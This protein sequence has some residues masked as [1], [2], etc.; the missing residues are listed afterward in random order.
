MDDKLKCD[1]QVSSMCKQAAKQLNALKRI[2][3]LLDQSSRLKIVR[4]YIMSNFIYCP[5]VWHFCSK[6]NLSKLERMQERALRFVYRDYKSSYEELLDQAKLQSLHLG[7][8]TSLA[9]EIHKTV[10]GGAP[11]YVSSLSTERES[12]YSLEGTTL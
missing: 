6:S 10:H 8:L 1:I 7:R 4:T 9:T 11:P 2:G 3:H 12:E 5:P